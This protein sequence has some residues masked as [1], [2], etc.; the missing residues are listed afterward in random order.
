MD[1]PETVLPFAAGHLCMYIDKEF[2]GQAYQVILMT[3]F[4]E[5]NSVSPGFSL[6]VS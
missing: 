6:R 3:L 4:E 2:D 1:R 5:L